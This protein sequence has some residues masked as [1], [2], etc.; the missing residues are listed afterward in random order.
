MPDQPDLGKSNEIISLT[1]CVNTL[2]YLEIELCLPRLTF[3]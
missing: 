2:W 1:L 3:T